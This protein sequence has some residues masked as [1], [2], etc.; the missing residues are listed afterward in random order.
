MNKADT[1][2]IVCHY[3]NLEIREQCPKLTHPTLLTT[4]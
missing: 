4:V 2:D 3:L 1:R